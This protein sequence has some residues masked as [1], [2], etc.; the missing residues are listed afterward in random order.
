MGQVTKRTGARA[1]LFALLLVAPAVWADWRSDQVECFR[2][3]EPL[4]K[5][6]EAQMRGSP[7]IEY[8]WRMTERCEV[9]PDRLPSAVEFTDKDG[10]KWRARWEKMK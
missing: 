8:C 6:C 2:A 5:K 4:Q 7:A 1:I 10:R 9:P 3:M